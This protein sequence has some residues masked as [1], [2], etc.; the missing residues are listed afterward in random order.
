VFPEMI[1]RGKVRNTKRPLL[2]LGTSVQFQRG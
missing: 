2:N 1:H